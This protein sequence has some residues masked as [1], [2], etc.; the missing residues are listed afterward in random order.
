MPASEY[1]VPNQT[2]N[3]FSFLGAGKP[4]PVVT[5]RVLPSQICSA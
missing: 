1:Y 2:I 3:P 5:I 4:A